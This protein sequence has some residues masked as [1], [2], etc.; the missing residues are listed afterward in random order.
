MPFKGG[1]RRIVRRFR[2]AIIGVSPRLTCA[3]T[4]LSFLSHAGVPHSGIPIVLNLQL[5]VCIGFDVETMRH[6]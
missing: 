4:G 6:A 3:R 1:F 2:R 5:K